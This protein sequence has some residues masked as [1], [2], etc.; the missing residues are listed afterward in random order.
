MLVGGWADGYRNNTFRTVA[1]LPRQGVPH[2]LLIGPWSHMSTATSLPGPHLDLVPGD[3]A[4]V[5]PLA[6]RRSTTAYDDEPALTW[7]AQR[8]TRPEPDLAAASRASGG[9]HRPGRSPA[10]R[11]DAR[12][13]ATA[14]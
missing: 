12:R 11:T 10:P 1:A 5:G 3:G 7:F 6:A 4:L 13:W 8:S 9:R 2:R 14:W